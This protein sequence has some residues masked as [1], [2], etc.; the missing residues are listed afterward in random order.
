[1]WTEFNRIA[2]MLWTR[3]H[4]RSDE[5]QALVE[6]SLILALVAVVAVAVLSNIGAD[7]VA[8]LE[9]VEKAF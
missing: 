9:R 7:V 5:G 1:M 8:K 6:Y 3:A 4:I 2:L